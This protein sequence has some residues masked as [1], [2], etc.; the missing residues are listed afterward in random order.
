VSINTRVKGP[1]GADGVVAAGDLLQEM[2]NANTKDAKHTKD[3][4]LEAVG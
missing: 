1:L 2:Q 3:T 4:K